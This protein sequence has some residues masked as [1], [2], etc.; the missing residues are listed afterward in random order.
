MVKNKKMSLTEFF[1][2]RKNILKHWP[3]G[4]HP[5][6][7]L[8]EAVKRL[9]SVPNHK[10]FAYKLREAK[11]LGITLIQPRAGVARLNEQVELLQY[12]EIEGKA[13]LL[14]STIDSYTRHNRYQNA[15]D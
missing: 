9:K 3:T 1:E 15:E 5:A 6:L 10:N 8:K 14:P 12:L 13:D 4:D 7:D 2:I 11:K